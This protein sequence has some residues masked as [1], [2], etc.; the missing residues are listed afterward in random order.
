LEEVIA[1]HYMQ[2]TVIGGPNGEYLI[3]VNIGI[4]WSAALSLSVTI[5]AAFFSLEE[6]RQ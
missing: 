2:N 6:A 5:L 4:V 1:L 3:D